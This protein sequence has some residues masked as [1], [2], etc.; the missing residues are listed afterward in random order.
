[1]LW[2]PGLAVQRAPCSSL[3]G[4]RQARRGA[5]S[6][7]PSDPLTV[8]ADRE[9]IEARRRALK[10]F[11]NLVAR[12]PRFSDDVV[13]KLFLAFSGPVSTLETRVAPGSLG[14]CCP[15]P[16]LCL[17][18][19]ALKESF[20]QVMAMIKIHCLSNFSRLGMVFRGALGLG[21]V[22]RPCGEVGCECSP[23]GSEADTQKAAWSGGF[24]DV[25]GTV[26]VNVGLLLG[27]DAGP[28]EQPPH[29]Q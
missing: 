13:L 7:Q 10:R 24:L 8:S 28:G 20:G 1:M 17:L 21:R 27:A 29:V 3:S 19:A 5:C 18:F 2:L 9:F 23:M 26:D 14:F 6:R 22:P 12:H 25:P 16:G 11:V 4:L 15:D